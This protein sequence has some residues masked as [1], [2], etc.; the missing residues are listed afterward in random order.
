VVVVEYVE[1]FHHTVSPPPPAAAITA[2]KNDENDML[3][4]HLRHGDR[5]DNVNE[6]NFTDIHEGCV[7]A[8][9]TKKAFISITTA[10]I[11]ISITYHMGTPEDDESRVRHR[12]TANTH[13]L[14]PTFS[15]YIASKCIQ[16]VVLP[17]SPLPLRFAYHLSQCGSFYGDDATGANSSNNN[18]QQEAAA[19]TTTCQ[20]ESGQHKPPVALVV[21]FVERYFPKTTN[22]GG[23]GRRGGGWRR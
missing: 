5:A 20:E 11:T 12:T 6:M 3:L 22:R 2:D 1:P 7:P 19:E 16:L 18:T 21:L 9:T 23:H 8:I 4:D 10:I 14:G 17:L 13:K 15:R